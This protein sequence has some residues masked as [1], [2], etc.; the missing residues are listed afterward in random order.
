MVRTPHNVMVSEYPS[1][2]F[3]KM[4][5][6]QPKDERIADRHIF[7]AAK[8]TATRDLSHRSRIRVSRDQVAAQLQ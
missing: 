6:P 4:A 5:N 1:G 3:I 8:P 2:N 7:Y